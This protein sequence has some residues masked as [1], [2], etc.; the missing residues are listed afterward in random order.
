MFAKARYRGRHRAVRPALTRNHTSAGARIG[1]RTRSLV[2]AGAAAAVVVMLPAAAAHAA[3]PL[4]PRAE[5]VKPPSDASTSSFYATLAATACTGNGSCV[6]GGSYDDTL[7]R[8]QAYVAT[9]SRGTWSRRVKLLLPP[10]AAAAQPNAQ[11]NGMACVSAGNCVAVGS[12]Y[13]GTAQHDD[14][15]IA[16]EVHGT[17]QRGFAPRSPANA[18]GAITYLNAVACTQ[19]GFCAAV[20]GYQDKAGHYQ[21]MALVKPVGKRWQP[22]TEILSPKGAATDPDTDMGG[23]ACTAVRKCVAVGSYSVPGSGFRV[24][25]MG[26]ILAG[27]GWHRAVRI[28]PPANALP[29]YIAYLHDVACRAGSCTAVGG[30]YF[31]SGAFRAMWVTE[32]NGHFRAGKEIIKAPADAAQVAN[33]SLFGISCPPT[34]H[35]VAAGYYTNAS[36]HQTAMYMTVASGR[37]TSAPLLPPLNAGSFR[38]VG[39]SVACTGTGHCTIVGWYADSA[40]HFRSEAASTG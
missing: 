21:T 9:E 24:Q 2:G 22:A 18:N 25:A 27:T 32:S 34:G 29:G 11:I 17:W 6:A 13:H 30:Y 16:M 37:W 23:V 36:G 15:L 12:F 8:T 38:S 26:A 28:T 10:S 19:T 5:Q 31:G 35:C 39:Y 20:G 7:G 40:N 4:F 1:R 33:T 3:G 14:A